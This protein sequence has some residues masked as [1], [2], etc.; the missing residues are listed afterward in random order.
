MAQR[1]LIVAHA[2]TPATLSLAFGKPFGPLSGE[3]R[4]LSGRVASWSSGP[5]DACR[6]TAVSLGGHPE[7]IPELRD[8]DLG[9]WAG[10]TLTDI[11]TDHSSELESWLHDP[12]AAPHGGESLAEL[13]TRVGRVLDDHPWPYG[14]SVVVVTSL[15]ARALIV[16]ALGAG[17]EVIFRIDVS[18]LGRAQISRGGTIWRLRELRA[19]RPSQQLT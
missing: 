15:V 14:R 1:L 11:A 3:V 9:T 10:R 16:H 13:I 6:A 5:E 18:P 19:L 7:S 2:A 17:P 12:Y 4:R 8:C